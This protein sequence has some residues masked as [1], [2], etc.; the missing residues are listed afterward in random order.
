MIG[1]ESE[2]ARFSLLTARDP[3]ENGLTLGRPFLSCGALGVFLT[4]LRL[5]RML[6]ATRFESV[7]ELAG[8]WRWRLLA[9]LHCCRL[10]EFWR[11]CFSVA[12]NFSSLQGIAYLYNFLDDLASRMLY[13]WECGVQ[14]RSDSPREPEGVS[15][16]QV[17]VVL[18]A[19][20][21]TSAYISIDLCS[22]ARRLT[23]KYFTT[24]FECN[25]TCSDRGRAYYHSK[26]PLSH[27]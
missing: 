7:V 12:V 22:M 23:K 17:L 20:V 3:L 10:P 16:L 1:L 4:R 26:R 6:A 11:K 25:S 5:L 14:I 18:R 2:L 8:W 13:L 15:W 24:I 27:A 19:E 9:A 21:H